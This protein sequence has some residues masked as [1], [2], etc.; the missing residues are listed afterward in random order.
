MIGG[1]ITHKLAEKTKKIVQAKWLSNWDGFH[2]IIERSIWLEL[3][4]MDTLSGSPLTSSSSFHW[5]SP[6][7]DV[8]RVGQTNGQTGSETDT[9]G[10]TQL[11]RFICTQRSTTEYNSHV[12]F[13]KMRVYLPM[14]PIR[15]SFYSCGSNEVVYRRWKW[16]WSTFTVFN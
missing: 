2:N 4:W 7:G 3:T 15:I 9:D 5:H 11:C 12:N 13:T 14:A 6:F 1:T 8:E 16:T 10:T